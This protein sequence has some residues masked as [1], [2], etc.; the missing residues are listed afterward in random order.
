[1]S[2]KK[3]ML[4]DYERKLLD[5][6]NELGLVHR[7]EHKQWK[8]PATKKKWNKELGQVEVIAVSIPDPQRVRINDRTRFII[9][10]TNV[11]IYHKNEGTTGRMLEKEVPV[12]IG[13]SL[14]S[15]LN[16]FDRQIGR[17]KALDRAINSYLNS[18]SNNIKE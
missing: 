15:Q 2:R 11:S 6:L 5:K 1:M 7:T 3:E 13:F 17:V 4:K 10:E 9:A 14:C 12:G 16:Q 18:E 8:Q